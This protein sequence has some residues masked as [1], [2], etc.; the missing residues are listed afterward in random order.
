[1]PLK[2]R[3]RNKIPI[4]EKKDHRVIDPLNQWINPL[5]KTGSLS[6]AMIV[7]NRVKVLNN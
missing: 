1:M 7:V 5:Y 4:R 2:I 6:K 3:S